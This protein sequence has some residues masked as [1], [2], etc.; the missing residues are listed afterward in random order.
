MSLDMESKYF[1]S[2]EVISTSNDESLICNKLNKL[3]EENGFNVPD[4]LRL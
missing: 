3:Q 4:W 1:S 2:D